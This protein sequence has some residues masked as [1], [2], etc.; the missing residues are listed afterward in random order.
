MMLNM[1]ALAVAR[2]TSKSERGQEAM[3]V[4][5]NTSANQILTGYAG[6]V[7]NDVRPS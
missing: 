3:K 7:H 2:Q 5:E 6:N 4:G 1:G